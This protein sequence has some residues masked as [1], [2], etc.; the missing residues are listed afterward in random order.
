MLF[1]DELGTRK[2]ILIAQESGI[3]VSVF[4]NA[5]NVAMRVDTSYMSVVPVQQTT[6]Q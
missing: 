2:I 6:E 4:D 3:F 5:D 1:D